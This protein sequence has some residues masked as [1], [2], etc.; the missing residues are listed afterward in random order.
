M[1]S[2]RHGRPRLYGGF[3]RRR[4]ARIGSHAA[5]RNRDRASRS[6]CPG[7]RPRAI[8][9]YPNS[10]WRRQRPPRCRA[11]WGIYPNVLNAEESTFVF[12]QNVLAEVLALF[13]GR[14]IHLGGDEVMKG[15][16]ARL[17]A[18][19]QQ[20][21]REL[22]SNE[23]ALHGYFRAAPQRLPRGARPRQLIGWD[24]I[25]EAG[26]R[27]ARWSCRGGERGATARRPRAMMRCWRRDPDAVLRSSA[28]GGGPE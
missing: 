20:R 7:T 3:Y 13:P 17:R 10:A 5:Q 18:G 1:T 2:I 4:R 14:Y 15:P 21:M 27:R 8:V 12:L 28:Q 16:M 26:C 22:A 24:E 25:L 11:D 9:R 23:A 6:T 19:V